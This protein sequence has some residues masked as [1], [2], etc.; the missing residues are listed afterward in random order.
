M[1][2]TTKSNDYYSYKRERVFSQYVSELERTIARKTTLNKC[3]ERET[4]I[5]YGSYI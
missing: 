1:I 2:L 4:L 5:I 3:N